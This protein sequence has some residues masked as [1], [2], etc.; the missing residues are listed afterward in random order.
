VAGER[1][2]AVWG[3]YH[4]ANLGDEL[5]VATIV[6]AIRR[7]EPEAAVVGI[8]M[9]PADTRERHGIDSVP[10]NPVPPRLPGAVA[11]VRPLGG[12]LA[13]VGRVL[14][15]LPFLVRSYR[16][17]RAVDLVVVA[18]S[19]QLLD[20]WRGPWLHPYTTYRWATLARL[21]RVP[22]VYPSMGAGPIDARLSA[23]FIRR[24]LAHAQDVTVRDESSGRVLAAI[25]VSRPL[26]VCPDMG[27]GVP[28]EWLPSPEERPVPGAAPVVGLNVMAHQD[29]RYWPRGDPVRYE[30]F[31]EKMVAFASWLLESGYRVRLF[32]SQ[33][34]AD[35]RVADDLVRL[36]E[37]RG[38]LDPERF[39][40]ALDDVGG[41]QDLVRVVAGCDL[42][43]A[44]RY[45]SVLLPL[46]LDIPV[47]GL[48][49]NPKTSELLK[50]AGCPERCLD[51]DAFT[52][53]EL[54]EAFRAL[55]RERDYGAREERRRRIAAHRAA[56]LDQFDRLFGARPRS[57]ERPGYS[58]TS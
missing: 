5:V 55:E 36:L 1:R 2:I 11:R 28:E 42:V 46:L 6:D 25:G 53:D 30:R 21:A 10:I 24:A 18:G 32:S 43:V 35:R 16:A 49:Y 51:I 58:Q 26:G 33:V 57:P 34:R 20:E 12:L 8:S 52:V 9:S 15:E 19:G 41:V 7:R 13:R 37:E 27:Y 4:G 3:H 23:F 54:V 50:D 31:L 39:R 48:A 45:H 40:P 29:R 22:M 17:L 44:A 38:S 56:V 47:L 14:S